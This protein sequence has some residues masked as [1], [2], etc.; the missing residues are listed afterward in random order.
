M[1]E[2]RNLEKSF[3]EKKVLKGLSFTAREGRAYGFLGRNGAGKTTTIRVLMNIFREDGGEALING[4]PAYKE[5]RAIGYLPEER[6]LYPKKTIR[7]QVRYLGQLKGFSASEAEKLAVEKLEEM[8]ATEYLD[9]KLNTLSKGNQQKI[10]LAV[11]LIGDPDIV[12]LDEPFSGLDPINAQM[13][14]AAVRRQVDMGKTVLFSSH[15][16]SQVEEFCDEICIIDDGRAVLEGNLAEIKRGYSR[17]RVYIEA[18]PGHDGK[19]AA[20][21]GMFAGAESNE[22]VIPRGDAFIYTLGGEGE[23]IK[24][25]KLELLRTLEEQN[26]GIDKFQVVEPTLEDI[27]VEKVGVSS[28]VDPATEAEDNENTKSKR[29]LFGRKK[30]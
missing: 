4:V 24:D 27:F 21:L 2:V 9:K 23:S 7:E 20:V 11:A 8:A 14:K 19:L 28:V 1:I 3:G 29:G 12:I 25:S 22:R 10:Q 13:L 18:E 5:S 26:V 6:G 17:D 30:A 16:M 15:Q